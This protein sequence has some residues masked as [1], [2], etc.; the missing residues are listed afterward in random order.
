M[1]MDLDEDTLKEFAVTVKFFAL[2]YSHRLPPELDV[3]DLIS[4]G[5][6]GL[7]DAA[8]RFDPSRGIKFKTLA[9]HRIRGAMLDEIRAA[10]WMPRSVREKLTHVQ[11]V[12]T[13]L[14]ARYKREPTRQEIAA[15]MDMTE[16]EFDRLSVDIE[17]HHLV[18]LEDLMDPEDGDSP[19]LLDRLSAPQEGDPLASLLQSE[20]SEKL[21]Q[22]L[23]RL[24]EK[25]RLVL[26]LYYYEELT[27]KEVA[28][29]VG[30]SE[31]RV[32]QIH[33]QALAA[34]KQSL[35][36]TS[37]TENVSSRQTVRHGG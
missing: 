36:E 15:R 6:G 8:R 27:M 24:P 23:D 31:S 21:C 4:A 30:V 29:V 1:P 2:R 33:G 3:D 19:S 5:M 22:A 32:S 28:R 25:Q 10:D 17:P 14:I 9:E 13:E 35:V 34:L 11:Q 12:K 16:E 7:L 26:S 18:S 37:E 20:V